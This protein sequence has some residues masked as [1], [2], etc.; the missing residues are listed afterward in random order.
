MSPSVADVLYI[1]DCSRRSAVQ[2]VVE[3]E[4][5]LACDVRNA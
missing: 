2:I 3:P 5:D 1:I 4:A